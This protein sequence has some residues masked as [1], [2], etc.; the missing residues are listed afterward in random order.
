MDQLINNW[1]HSLNVNSIDR[2]KITIF[3]LYSM[4]NSYDDVDFESLQNMLLYG[5][6]HNL[7][8]NMNFVINKKNEILSI[9]SRSGSPERKE[10]YIYNKIDYLYI[11]YIVLIIAFIYLN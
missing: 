8:D 4:Y 5:D 7:S 2:E 11:L 6:S 9:R 3:T 10:I 1:I